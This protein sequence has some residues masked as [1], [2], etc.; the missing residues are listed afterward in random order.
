MSKL[1]VH[2]SVPD[3]GTQRI[4]RAP[5]QSFINLCV[6]A[7]FILGPSGCATVST[8]EKP[9][10]DPTTAAPVLEDVSFRLHAPKMPPE[11][12][13]ALKANYYEALRN[14]FEYVP[15]LRDLYKPELMEVYSVANIRGQWR[16]LA[17]FYG[18]PEELPPDHL[19]GFSV[20][21][22]NSSSRDIFF[23]VF[24]AHSELENVATAIEVVTHELRHAHQDLASI[25][26]TGTLELS[27]GRREAPVYHAT[28]VDLLMIKSGW[29]AAGRDS[30]AIS[31]I[32]D[33]VERQEAG[34]RIYFRPSL[35][36][37]QRNLSITPDG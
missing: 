27:R 29:Q 15:E 2:D 37:P 24:V 6:L 8:S 13:E 31:A 20:A 1:V 7:A 18:M 30:V 32:Q 23:K 11:K 22:A 19:N 12:T 5:N 36:R 16:E 21:L 26:E 3:L 9:V 35:H 34:F 14:I 33:A 25:R 4:S 28:G 17:S 10:A